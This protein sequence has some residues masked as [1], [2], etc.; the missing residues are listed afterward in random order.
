MPRWAA[1]PRMTSLGLAIIGPKS[2]IAPTPKKI[3]GGTISSCHALV[4]VVEQS[5]RK[6]QV[7]AR[8]VGDDAGKAD[9]DQQQRLV[10]LDDGEQIIAQPIAIITTLPHQRWAT[11]VC[12]PRAPKNVKNLIEQDRRIL[13]PEWRAD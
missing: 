5:A 1:A 6:D 9:A 2:V 4:G 3:S 11:P 13:P 12:A 7:G 10:L 8:H